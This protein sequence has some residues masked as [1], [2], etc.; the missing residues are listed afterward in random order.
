[1]KAAVWLSNKGRADAFDLSPR[2]LVFAVLTERD[3][4]R[5]E[6]LRAAQSTR[7]GQADSKD[8][9]KAIEELTK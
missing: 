9:K 6:M 8:Y 7:I 3:E 1:V 5:A 2:Q 4:Q